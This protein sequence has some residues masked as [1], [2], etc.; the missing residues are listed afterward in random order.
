MRQGVQ[1]A[2]LR[3]VCQGCKYADDIAVK[4]NLPREHVYTHLRRLKSKD[5][6]KSY[7]CR[8][9]RGY[10]AYTVKT[11]E[12]FMMSIWTQPAKSIDTSVKCDGC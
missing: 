1:A 9:K 8:S 7:R 5:L 11:I 6:I 10:K 2:V 3:L 12:V 4:L